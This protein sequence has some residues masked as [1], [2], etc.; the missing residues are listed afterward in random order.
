LFFPFHV[1]GLVTVGAL[2]LLT[3]YQLHHLLSK[4]SLPS[5]VAKADGT[6]KMSQQMLVQLL[7]LQLLPLPVTTTKL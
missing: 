4:I 3:Q 6:Q 7:L 2:F 1:A 5:A